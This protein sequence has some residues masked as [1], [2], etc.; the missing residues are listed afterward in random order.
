MGTA[1]RSWYPGIASRSGRRVPSATR[2]PF[3]DSGNRPQ[4]GELR[5]AHDVLMEARK[6]AEGLLKAYDERLESRGRG[7]PA[8]QDYD[9]MR[10]MLLFACAG[11]DSMTKHLIEDAL[12]AVISRGEKPPGF[13]TFVKRRLERSKDVLSDVLT[14]PDPRTRLIELLVEDVTARSLQSVEEVRRVGA[15]L[16]LDE[17]SLIEDPARLK[18]AFDARNAIAHEMDIDLTRSNRS[19]TPRSREDMVDHARAVLGCAAGLLRLVDEKLSEAGSC[20]QLLAAPAG[21]RTLIDA[22]RGHGQVASGGR[23]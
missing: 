10:A 2:K 6:T 8:E 1:P 14:S 19:R 15:Y 7:T 12:P 22:T 20:R 13:R 21:T 16:G 23:G 9:L 17:T 18:D 4:A 5:R 11:L 3:G